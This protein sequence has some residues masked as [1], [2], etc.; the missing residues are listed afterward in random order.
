MVSFMANELQIPLVSFSATDPSLSSLQYP[1]FLRLTQSDSYQMHAM[2][3]LINYYGWRQVIGIYIDNEYGRNGMNSLDD[4]LSKKMSMIYK[5]AL[6]LG[7]ARQ[8]ILDAL[9]NSKVIG[10][11]VYVVHAHPDLGLEIFSVAKRLNM[12]TD[13]YVWLVTDWLCTALETFK[14]VGNNSQIHL[15][16]IVGFCQHVPVSGQKRFFMS[17]WEELLRKGVVTSGL[18][19]YGFYAY[20]AVWAVSHA[21][22][23]FFK[24]SGNVSFTSNKNLVKFRGDIHLDKLKTFSGG[25]LLREKLLLLNFT[26]LTGQVQFDSDRNL[27]SG[28]YE[29][30]NIH[31]DDV[32]QTVGY[33]TSP[34]GLTMSLP[35]YYSGS[36]Q[37]NSSAKHILG[38]VTWPGGST[39]TPRGWVVATP[40]RIAVPHRVS[41]PEFV[42]VLDDNSTVKGYCIDVFKAAIKLVPYNVP[43]HFV[44][45]GDGHTAPSYWKLVNMVADGVILLITIF[46]EFICI[47]I[48]CAFLLYSSFFPLE[49]C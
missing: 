41:F 45:F 21:I 29:I 4:E 40:L 31:D 38:T 18:N 11:R 24:D 20:D 39:Q 33:W 12:M 25:Q 27:K 1:F 3:D 22:D 44:P 46:V 30:F 6:P 34:L 14:S 37:R 23:D 36:G 42:S 17:K 47:G 8:H 7:T 9:Q 49:F 15:Q 26:G 28:T 2:A 48:K 43:Y 5:I 32:T 10:P 19:A 13:E 16:G 35:N